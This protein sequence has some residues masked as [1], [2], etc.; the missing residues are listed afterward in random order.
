MVVLG[1]T[2]HE[3]ARRRF[4]PG[5]TELVDGRTKSDHDEIQHLNN[6]NDV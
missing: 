1:T 2:I 4:D 5:P 6:A 3:F